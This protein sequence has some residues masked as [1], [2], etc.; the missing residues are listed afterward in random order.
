MTKFTIAAQNTDNAKHI[1]LFSGATSG[2][3]QVM[4]GLKPTTH[5]L[6]ATINRETGKT[7]DISPAN[8][9][10]TNWGVW[11]HGFS[12][13][14]V[15]D[16]FKENAYDATLVNFGMSE[17]PISNSL[18][19]EVMSILYT[20]ESRASTLIEVLWRIRT[21]VDAGLG[22]HTAGFKKAEMDIPTYRG[23]KI[24]ISSVVIGR[25]FG[26]DTIQMVTGKLG[27][28]NHRVGRSNGPRKPWVN[29]IG[30]SDSLESAKV[31]AWQEYNARADVLNKF[32]ITTN[33]VAQ[34]ADAVH[35]RLASQPIR[36][37][38]TLNI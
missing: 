12:R 15:M 3:H 37:L 25:M 22:N 35:R 20:P 2:Q 27:K 31:A 6:K 38:D 8:I 9:E 11:G 19:S 24:F 21:M 14:T 29:L 30:D 28:F 26:L 10:S 23:E 1:T 7:E 33:S 13:T 4:V 16:H 5:F 34:L 36:T 32:E 18:T 17:S